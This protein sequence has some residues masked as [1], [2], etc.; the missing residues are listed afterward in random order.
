M[1][2]IKNTQ[3][4]NFFKKIFIKFCRL[5]GYEIIDQS[6]FRSTTLNKNLNETL[7]VQG[8]KSITIPLGQ[9]D[10]KNKINSLKIIVR[11]CTSEL[12]MDQ[13]KRRIFNEEKNEYTFRTLRSLIK[14]IN[15]ASLE[16]KN[17]R[18]NLIV[19]D[20]NSPKEDIYKIK[21][22]LNKSNIENKFQSINLED[23]KD[24]IKPGYSK[25]KFSNMANFYTSLLIAK[26]ES[27]DIIYFV[28]D[29]Y[30][31]SENAITEMIFSYEKFNTIFSKDLV[32]LPSDYPYLY[33]KDEATKIYLGEKYHWRLVSESL[34][35]F[36]TSKKVIE[37]NYNSLEKMGIEWVDPWEKPL[38][39]IYNSNPCLSPIPSLAV[40]CANINSVFGVSPFIDLKKLWENNES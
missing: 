16:F 7:R 2:K 33:T 25:A 12:I 21:E 5:L 13:N 37:E 30:L 8:K 39:D 19:T 15:K 18:F 23:F 36:M 32:L 20:T 29:D 1:K 17:I 28:E 38:H 34:V 11:T 14:S 40:H 22:I 35:T 10:I 26:K 24:K 31:H 3:K 4:T 6:N 9:V 27:A